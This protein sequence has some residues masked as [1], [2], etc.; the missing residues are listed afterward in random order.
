MGG[1]ASSSSSSAARKHHQL[2]RNPV[3]QAVAAR[4]AV[5]P[6]RARAPLM[7]EKQLVVGVVG[8]TGAVGKE[9][10]QV[11]GDR[12]FPVA[13]LRSGTHC[14]M[15]AS[16]EEPPPVAAPP[17]Q[18]QQ[19]IPSNYLESSLESSKLQP[20]KPSAPPNSV[21]PYVG[22]AAAMALLI[23]STMLFPDTMGKGSGMM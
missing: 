23:G 9:I 19:S 17:Q 20:P 22:Y 5:A 12:K 4:S 13:Q 18:Q 16:E 14:R 2:F 6:Q 1:R 10:V 11:L 15:Q 7:E 21:L 8:V 3:V